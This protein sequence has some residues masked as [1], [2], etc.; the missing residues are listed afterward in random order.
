MPALVDFRKRPRAIETRLG[1]GAQI[2]LRPVRP[3]DESAI[4]QGI[5]DLSDKS[6]YLRFFSS[7]ESAPPTVIQRLSDVDG[8]EHI[9]WG[10]VMTGEEGSPPVGAAHA[11]RH[12]DDPEAADFAIAVLDDYHHRGI[13]RMLV[14][15]LF[16]DCRNAR[17]A[18]LKFDI[19]Y[20][21]KAAA[22]LAKS[23]G[24][25]ASSEPGA[26]MS[27]DLDIDEALARLKEMP[28]PGGLED[29]FAAFG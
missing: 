9:A 20:G 14:A 2:C 11:T 7:F 8:F 12:S 25:H 5:R 15:A 22:T 10:A 19:L 27:Y 4:E 17:L 26:V 6:R 1:D 13:A 28:E 23:F 21:N 24:A 3:S 16:L 18:R 29:V